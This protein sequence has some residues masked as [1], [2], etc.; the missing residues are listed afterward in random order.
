MRGDNLK[1]RLFSIPKAVKDK[2]GVI[3][4]LLIVKEKH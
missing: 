1:R 2:A 4:Y 3:P